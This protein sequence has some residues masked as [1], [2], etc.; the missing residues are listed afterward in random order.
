MERKSVSQK[1]PG[2]MYLGSLAAKWHTKQKSF[3][4]K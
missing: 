1:A 4:K 2:S 3:F